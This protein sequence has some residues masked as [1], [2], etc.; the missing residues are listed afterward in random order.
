MNSQNKFS[1]DEL[2]EI[3]TIAQEDLINGKLFQDLHTPT[4][5]E[6]VSTRVSIILSFCFKDC[7][8]VS[9]TAKTEESCCG[10]LSHVVL[11]AKPPKSKPLKRRL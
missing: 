1:D 7:Y 9:Q 11:Q 10:A 8:G 4:A 2:A 3:T 6:T 5:F